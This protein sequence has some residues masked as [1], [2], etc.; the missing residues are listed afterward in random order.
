MELPLEINKASNEGPKFSIFFGKPK[1]GKTSAFVKLKNHLLID[2]DNGS[3]YVNSMRIKPKDLH[4]L[5]EAISLIKKKNEELGVPCY[6]YIILDTGTVLEDFVLPYAASLYRN[7]EL[8][9]RWGRKDDGTID[10]KADV[11]KLPK[12]A[13]YLYL[14]EAYL[15]VLERLRAITPHF[16]LICHC[17]DTQIEK[18]GEEMSEMT[19]ALGGQLK[20]IVAS[21]A[22]AI[23][24]IYRK[25]S[26][27]LVDFNNGES[28]SG[29]ARCLYLKNRKFPIITSDKENPNDESKFIYNADKIFDPNASFDEA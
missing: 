15:D 19:I 26:D 29:Q 16:I 23:G 3:D 8:G 21:R 14:R 5:F 6:D 4:E 20:S 2:I 27:T 1:V 13:G 10:P 9:K 18:E 25:G 12:G 11:K 22:D 24:Y 17:I 7:T 28:S